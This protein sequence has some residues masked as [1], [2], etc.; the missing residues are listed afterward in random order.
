MFRVICRL[1]VFEHFNETQKK[2]SITKVPMKKINTAIEKMEK[3]MMKHEEFKLISRE[4]EENE[5][6]QIDA[7]ES[8]NNSINI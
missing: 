7:D 4:P 2:Y 5:V 6:I 3:L 8:T 1:S